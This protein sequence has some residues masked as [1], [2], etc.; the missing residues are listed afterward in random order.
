MSADVASE[1]NRIWHAVDTLTSQQRRSK[2]PAALNEIVRLRHLAVAHLPRDPAPSWPASYRDPFPDVVGQ[3]PEIDACD[4]TTD[5][6]GGAIHHH[7][8]LLVRNLLSPSRVSSLRVNIDRA[9]A[10]RTGPAPADA[11][12][13]PFVPEPG[14]PS[15]V[16]RR[17]WVEDCGAMWSA[18][19]PPAFFDIVEA[20]HDARIPEIVGTYLGEP[21]VLSVNKCTMRRVSPET[22][23]SWHQDGAFMGADVRTVDVWISFT[24]CGGDTPAPGLAVVPR[25]MEHLL[26][27]GTG[28]A[29]VANG[30]DEAE[31]VRVLEGQKPATPHF[32]PG[33]ALLFDGLFV[34][35]TG[36]KP[37]LTE[38]R[39]ALET[40][41]F[42]PSTF[43]ATYVPLAV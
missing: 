34:H 12:Y 21:P 29:L 5:A 15:L 40:W 3:P 28:S 26:P 1:A 23:P 14:Y 19:S 32:R 6:L 18:D 22:F 17:K 4:L 25:R 36:T 24:E 43:P 16:E 7:G 38:W 13:S 39:E 42:T 41:F 9:F 11:W 37:G 30:I 31:V 27:T 35:C 8:C 2:D 33:D 10:A 20:M